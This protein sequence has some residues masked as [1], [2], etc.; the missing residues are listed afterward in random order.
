MRIGYVWRCVA[1]G[2]G[3]AFVRGAPAREPGATPS[4]SSSA[5]IAVPPA[6]K[7]ACEWLTRP[8][9][10]QRLEAFGPAAE[11]WLWVFDRP[12]PQRIWIVRVDTSVAGI[13]FLVTEPDPSTDTEGKR[14]ET[15]CETTLDFARRTGVGIAVNTSAFGPLRPRPGQPMDVAGLAAV[16]GRIY[17]KPV[18]DYGAMYVSKSGRV[19]LRGPPLEQRDI[20]HVI[21][22]FRMLLDDSVVAVPAADLTTSFGQANPRTAVG[23]DRAGKTLWIVV[24]DGRQ[25]GRAIGLTLAELAALFQTLGAFDA[26]N[27]D[28]GGSTA[29]V[30]R[31]AAGSAQILNTPIHAGLP[32]N[33]RQVATNLGLILPGKAPAAA[34]IRAARD[35]LTP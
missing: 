14:Y 11:I 29:L 15:R 20:W 35:G 24:A 30:V 8:L 28:G 33:L 32:G 4:N 16:D 6:V 5:I 25:P 21:A 12:H 17:S 2:V 31:D 7:A 10:S 13:R 22:G 1:M 9:H 23:V 27:L 26:L 3:L 18:K 19:A 34:D